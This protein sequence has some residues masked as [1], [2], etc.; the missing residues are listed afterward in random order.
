[1]HLSCQYDRLYYI[2][3]FLFASGELS[4]NRYYASEDI[5]GRAVA[6]RLGYGKMAIVTDSDI[7][8][9]GYGLNREVL[10]DLDNPQPDFTFLIKFG[11]DIK[12]LPSSS[13]ELITS[14]I[15]LT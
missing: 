10:L 15:I 11:L 9:M 3:E 1:M 2:S 12:T 14:A 4:L 13:N 5:Q 6:R 7:R 8:M